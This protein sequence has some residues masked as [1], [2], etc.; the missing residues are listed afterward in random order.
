[1]GMIRI[2]GCSKAGA[3]RR[4]SWPQVKKLRMGTCGVKFGG[5]GPIIGGDKFRVGLKKSFLEEVKIGKM[6]GLV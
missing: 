6:V 4:G 1:M 3:V 2:A 5:L